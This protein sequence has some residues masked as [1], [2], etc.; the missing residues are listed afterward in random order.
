MLPGLQEPGRALELRGRIPQGRG[1]DHLERGTDGAVLFEVSFADQRTSQDSTLKLQLCT[2]ALKVS[3]V[4]H[5]E[6]PRLKPHPQGAGSW[7]WSAWAHCVQELRLSRGTLPPHA[8]LGATS[9]CQRGTLDRVWQDTRAGCSWQA[10]GLLPN[11]L[12]T[13]HETAVSSVPTGLSL[14]GTDGSCHLDGSGHLGF[15]C[16]DVE[17]H[18]V[19]EGEVK[20][21]LIC[22][23]REGATLLSALARSTLRRGIYMPPS[24]DNSK[25]GREAMWGVTGS[26]GTNLQCHPISVCQAVSVR[27]KTIH[28]REKL[29][30]R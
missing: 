8:A 21:I 3:Q 17:V 4:G 29:P 30:T 19:V 18:E 16:H 9:P 10:E 1:V 6:G 25:Q 13:G 27:P 7:A 12:R 28:K 22:A 24:L 5:G 20:H 26:R 23:K 11:E 15:H 2:K 14:P